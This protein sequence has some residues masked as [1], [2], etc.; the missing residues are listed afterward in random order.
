VDGLTR[1][2]RLTVN[3]PRIC[4]ACGTRGHRISTRREVNGVHRR[5]ECI[6]PECRWRWT[7]IELDLDRVKAVVALEKAFTEVSEALVEK[8][9]LGMKFRDTLKAKR[10]DSNAVETP[11]E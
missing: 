4:A 6:N 11:A 9:P 5:R 7:T 3:D 10:E 2:E 8:S 1:E